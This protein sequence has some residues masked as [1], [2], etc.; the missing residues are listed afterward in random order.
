MSAQSLFALVG[1][2]L[3][4]FSSAMAN[5]YCYQSG[6]GLI[7][8]IEFY[9]TIEYKNGYAIQESFDLKM[10]ELDDSRIAGKPYHGPVPSAT[11]EIKLKE[12]TP[13]L[14]SRLR[15]V[16]AA[17][18]QRVQKGVVQNKVELEKICFE[19]TPGAPTPETD[20]EASDGIAHIT[21]IT[22]LQIKPGAQATTNIR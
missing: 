6:T 9:R 2:G 4:S 17:P 3:F 5:S 14:L 8:K 7:G 21:N 11:F 18:G 13:S 12:Q 19:T 20:L 16:L 1:I 15:S 10:V 22:E